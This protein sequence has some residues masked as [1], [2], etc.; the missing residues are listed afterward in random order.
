MEIPNHEEREPDYRESK[1]ARPK[2]TVKKQSSI[3]TDRNS[4]PRGKGA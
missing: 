4:E 3:E 1:G 2:V